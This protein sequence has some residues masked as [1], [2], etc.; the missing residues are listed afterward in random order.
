MPYRK[1]GKQK[2]RELRRR[3]L[4]PVH[5][6][7]SAG[8]GQAC[9]LNVSSRG[10]LIYASG[11]APTD[12]RVELRQGNHAIVARVV[13]RKGQRLGLATEDVGRA[14]NDRD[15]TACVARLQAT[16]AACQ[17]VA[18]HAG[19]VAVGDDESEPPG[20]PLRKS[21]HAIV[22]STPTSGHA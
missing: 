12:D 16:D 18:V 13:W 22:G 19:H 21:L 8:W 17:L 7:T 14:G 4:L 1:S 6:R 9:I 5:I 15:A 2:S 10:L 11:L 3:V 20:L